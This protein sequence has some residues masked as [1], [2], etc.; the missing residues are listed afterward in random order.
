MRGFLLSFVGA[1]LVA[2]FGQ[3]LPANAQPEV[4]LARSDRNS[5]SASACPALANARQYD[6]IV[7]GDEVP[8]VMSALKV[9]QE[10]QARRQSSKVALITEGDTTR[11]IGGHLVRGGLAI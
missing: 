8:G 2:G 10:L 4:D 7:F 1:T 11:G 6:V 5:S 9:Q 3:I